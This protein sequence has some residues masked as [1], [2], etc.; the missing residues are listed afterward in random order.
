VAQSWRSGRG[1]AKARA[2]RPLDP[3]ALERFALRYVERYAT[4]RAK[5]ATYLNRKIRERGWEGETPPAVEAIVARF[6]EL[7]YV[8]D[9]AFAVARGASL[10]RR[11]YGVRRV[12]AT[13]KAAGIDEEDAAP[14]EEAARE[15][16]FAAALTFA[17][18]KRIGPFAAGS[19][20]PAGRQ[21]ALAA[22]L[23]AGHDFGI[24]RE[25]IDRAPGDVP[26]WTSVNRV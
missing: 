4:T 1:G 7:G 3:A 5:L 22:M 12:S 9:A 6:A 23:R 8:D 25:I 13:L 18:R 17:R 26:D 19:P 10:T 2:S 16:A 15:D 20:D 11:G 24:S 14:A 21:K